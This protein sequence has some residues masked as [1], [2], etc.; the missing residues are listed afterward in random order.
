LGK[1]NLENQRRG[2]PP[3]KKFKVS[4]PRIEGNKERRGEGRGP[5]KRLRF[6]KA[7]GDHHRGDRKD[8]SLPREEKT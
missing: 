3:L 2:H 4:C 6:V 5:E 8:G 7:G 1:I